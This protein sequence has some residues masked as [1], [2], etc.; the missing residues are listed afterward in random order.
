MFCVSPVLQHVVEKSPELGKRVLPATEAD[1]FEK[2]IHSAVDEYQLPLPSSGLPL[3]SYAVTV[4][5]YSATRPN[6]V[7]PEQNFNRV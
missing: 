5:T 3:P 2:V 1:N 7:V 4:Q 6:Q